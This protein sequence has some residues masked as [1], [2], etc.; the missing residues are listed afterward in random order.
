M[1]QKIIPH[2]IKEKIKSILKINSLGE[3][4]QKVNKKLNPLAKID[5]KFKSLEV[6]FNNL[7]TRLNNLESLLDYSVIK[8]IDLVSYFGDLY[9]WYTKDKS[10]EWIEF[11]SSTI[12]NYQP[13]EKDFSSPEIKKYDLAHEYQDYDLNKLHLPEMELKNFLFLY[14]WLQKIDFTYLD[15]GANMGTTTI[16]AAKFFQKY[17]QQNKIISFEPGIVYDLLKH[18]IKINRVSNL[19]TL[20]NLAGGDRNSS[21]IIKSLLE[22]SESNSSID[23]RE[24]CPDLLLA[25]CQLVDS[26]RL[27][28]YVEEKQI[29]NPLVVKIDTEGNDWQVI[30]GLEKLIPQQVVMI[31]VEYTPAL[32]RKYIEPE[33][34]LSYLNEKYLLL[35]MLTLTPCP[36][37]KCSLI[38]EEIDSF[39]EFAQQVEGFSRGWTDVLA[40]RRDLPNLDKLIAKL[41]NDGNNDWFTENNE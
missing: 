15:I 12:K 3:L 19:V 34:V 35:N 27:D 23:F 37:W 30:K 40:I 26:V 39:K 21:V 18:T 10:Y 22:H 7:E 2:K 1:L 8:N 33:E 29:K 5:A 25:S 6:E 13:S 11:G 24:F 31:I 16:P 17:Q 28:E 9:F 4:P 38:G 41:T 20:E 14:L 32:M 36:Y